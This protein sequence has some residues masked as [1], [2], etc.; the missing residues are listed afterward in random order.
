MSR[1]VRYSF[2]SSSLIA[3]ADKWLPV[4]HFPSFWERMDAL[5][6]EDRVLIS[7]EVVAELTRQGSS[8]RAWCNRHPSTHV[9]IDEIQAEAR[10][11]VAQF[12]ELTKPGRGRADGWVVAL[13]MKRKATVVTDEKP[14]GS[15]ARKRPKIPD[16][17]HEFGIPVI[18]MNRLVRDEGWVF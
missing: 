3:G 9:S 4:E 17:C 18:P 1:R 14:T 7:D 13:A 11:V 15:K 2:D 16:V 10:Q 8:A 12:G 5:V 6:A